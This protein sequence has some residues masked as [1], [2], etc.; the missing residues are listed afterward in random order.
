V[1]IPTPGM[2]GIPGAPN[3]PTQPITPGIP[4]A[5]T[6]PPPPGGGSVGFSINWGEMLETSGGAF[7]PL[8]KSTY[9]VLVKTS[10]ATKTTTDK[11]MFKVIFTVDGG[12]YNG[13]TLYHN[14]VVSPEN[15]NAMRMFFLNMKT[16][17]LDAD[18]FSMEPMP[19]QIAAAMIGRA[20]TVAV[21]HRLYQGQWRENVKTLMPRAGGPVNIG[22]MSGMPVPGGAQMPAA[23]AIMPA[24]TNYPSAHVQPPQPAPV[25]SQPAPQPVPSAPPTPVSPVAPTPTPAAAVVESTHPIPMPVNAVPPEPGTPSLVNE[26]G[27]GQPSQEPPAPPAPGPVVLPPGM[28]QDQ[29]EQFL[30]FQAA[31]MQAQTPAPAPITP[32]QAAPAAPPMPGAPAGAPA[33][34]LPGA[35]AF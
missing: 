21:D 9:N 32:V 23:P 7:E 2:P 10:E 16:F 18:F 22:A 8:P 35:E 33:F 29:Y 25:I 6:P 27:S 28:T 15:P 30:A 24:P 31:Q 1:T 26:P 20:A 5:Q 17:G 13:R 3:F 11:L 34:P 14:I 12:P 19:E 4:G